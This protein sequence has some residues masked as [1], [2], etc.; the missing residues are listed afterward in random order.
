MCTVTS[1]K[2]V[3]KWVGKWNMVHET[4]LSELVGGDDRPEDVK[5]NYHSTAQG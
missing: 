3:K 2:I 4:L 5:L 1:L